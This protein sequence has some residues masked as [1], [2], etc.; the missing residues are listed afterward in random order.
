VADWRFKRASGGNYVQIKAVDWLQSWLIIHLIGIDTE[1]AEVLGTNKFALA[2]KS[3]GIEV[4]EYTYKRSRIYKLMRKYNNLILAKIPITL[5]EA[6]I[7]ALEKFF[8]DPN[9]AEEAQFWSK[10]PFTFVLY[11]TWAMGILFNAHDVEMEDLSQNLTQLGK[12]KQ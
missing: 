12:D 10:T 5:W 2:C 3:L 1:L 11:E 6:Q 7:G 4:S 8:E 9:N